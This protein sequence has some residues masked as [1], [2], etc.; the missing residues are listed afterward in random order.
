[1][2]DCGLITWG[3]V[4]CNGGACEPPAR[5]TEPRHAWERVPRQTMTEQRTKKTHSPQT[6]IPSCRAEKCVCQ[7]AATRVP[8]LGGVKGPIAER[9]CDATP[10][11]KGRGIRIGCG[12]GCAGLFD[13]RNVP[14]PK[15]WLRSARNVRRDLV[16]LFWLFV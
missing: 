4:V 7:P 15:A 10:G 6:R 2:H 12:C 3:A 16:S 8:M 13:A 11:E 1:V 9:G 14:M 5:L